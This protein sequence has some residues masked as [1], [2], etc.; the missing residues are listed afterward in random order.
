MP[1]DIGRTLNTSTRAKWNGRGEQ[2]IA[3]NS[4]RAN[5]NENNI[6]VFRVK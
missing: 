6:N 4:L 1:H 5:S 2:K 3:V